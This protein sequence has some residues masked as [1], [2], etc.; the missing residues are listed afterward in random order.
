MIIKF[1]GIITENR[2]RNV[3]MKYKHSQMFSDNYLP[4]HLQPATV[5]CDRYVYVYMSSFEIV[6]INIFKLVP[7]KI[8]LESLS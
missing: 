5:M 4:N 1:S 6:Y 8:I 2:T 7:L 3:E